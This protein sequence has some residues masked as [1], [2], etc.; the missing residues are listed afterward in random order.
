MTS[1]PPLRPRRELRYYSAV[2]KLYSST[3]RVFNSATLRL[4]DL[5]LL[6]RTYSRQCSPAGERKYVRSF[7]YS[8]YYMFS[9]YDRGNLKHVANQLGATWRIFEEYRAELC[10]SDLLF[11][12]LYKRS[13][14]ANNTPASRRIHEQAVVW[15]RLLEPKI[16]ATVSL[17]FMY[18]QFLLT[19]RELGADKKLYRPVY[20]TFG[21]TNAER[22]SILLQMRE[23]QT[24]ATRHHMPTLDAALYA[25]WGELQPLS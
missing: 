1:P 9:V 6:H 21:R 18:A 7:L 2:H 23:S 25:T 10:E 15:L 5:E 20:T 3:H 24:A 17:R 14:G 22:A 12:I 4:S 8:Y 19:L 13:F 16:P 11:D